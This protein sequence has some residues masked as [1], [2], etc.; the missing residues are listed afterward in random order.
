M[1]ECNSLCLDSVRVTSLCCTRLQPCSTTLFSGLIIEPC[2]TR[3]YQWRTGLS[4]FKFANRDVNST[5]L[6]TITNRQPTFSLKGNVWIKSCL[7]KITHITGTIFIKYQRQH[8][9][10]FHALFT[11]QNCGVIRRREFVRA[12]P[13]KFLIPKS[14]VWQVTLTIKAS[15]TNAQAE[16]CDLPRNAMCHRITTQKSMKVADL[17]RKVDEMPC[18]GHH[19]TGEVWEKIEL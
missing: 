10:I 16:E 17:R 9:S 19:I 14:S 1:E 2:D 4:N 12:L 18:N 15:V 8:I 6:P 13:G 7:D 3:C 11:E 5:C